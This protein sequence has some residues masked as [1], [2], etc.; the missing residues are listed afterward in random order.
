[1]IEEGGFKMEALIFGGTAVA[2]IVS[3]IVYTAMDEKRER[4]GK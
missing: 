2:L 4:R 3:A 1:M